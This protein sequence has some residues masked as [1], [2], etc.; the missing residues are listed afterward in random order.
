MLKINILSLLLLSSTTSLIASAGE[1][2]RK[3]LPIH[4]PK[5]PTYT[6]L[7]VRNAKAPA[8]FEIK[9]P[10][11]APNILLILI[12]DMGFGVSQTFGGPAKMPTID[13]LAKTGIR[14]NHFHT[15]SLCAP[16]RTALLS[17]RNHH[18]NN[19]G[20]ITETATAFPGNTGSTPPESAPIAKVLRYNGYS[21]AMF[22]KNH[23]TAAWEVSP[24][25]PTDRWPTR[26]GFDKFYG[27]FGGETNQWAPLIYDGMTPVEIPEDPEYN[28]MTDMTDKAIEWVS[29]QQALTPDKPFF[30][31]FAPGATHAP[32]H[33]PK[34]W[35]EKYKG[36]FDQGWDKL[37]E[38]TLARQIKQGIVP[39]GTKLAPK[40]KDIKDWDTLS[41]D[42]KRLF[43]RQMETFA[44]FA[45]YADTEIG[46]LIT[47]LEEM[48][49]LDNTLVIYIAGDNGT[50]AEGGMNGVVNEYTELN[51]VH[52]TIE[53]QLKYLDQWGN[54]KTY[55]HMAAGWAIA[56]GAPFAWAKQVAGDFGGT[57]NGMVM[58]WPKHFK[59][60]SVVRSQFAHVTDIVPTI[61]EASKI[62]AP[63]YV[64]G[65]KQL[66]IQG[67][68][69]LYTFNAPT[70]AER[71]TSQYFEMFGNRGY[72][73]DGWFAR[74]VHKKPWSGTPERSLQDD[75]WELFD[76]KV[77][78][79]LAHNLA[80][81]HPTKLRE[82]KKLFMKD[83]SL[84]HVLPIDDRSFERLNSKIAGRP[85]LM[86]GRT[87]ITLA[88]GMKDLGENVFINVK[89]TSYSIDADILFL[90]SKK[91]GVIIAQGG[92][93]GGWS[94]F[95][96]KGKASYTYNFLGQTYTTVMDKNTLPEG[97]SNVRMEFKYDGG[98]AGKGGQAT[99]FVNGKK[100][101]SKRVNRTQPALFSMDE[102]ADVGID[103]AT[104]VDESYASTKGKF[105][106][107]VLKVT[108]SI[109]PK[110]TK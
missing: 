67:K 9:T 102:T 29:F 72:Y 28:F 110:L 61:L 86:A 106:G 55:P 5:V 81:T 52:E 82:L 56:S 49:E 84:N 3:V 59:D 7:D 41:S 83:A 103:G 69:L 88:D 97:K 12:D 30:L 98:G 25:G 47:K 13:A 62:P 100:V 15:T 78:F 58:R 33:V 17:G 64:D 45:E 4:A 73:K 99:L 31:Y 87:S 23:E 46:R 76:T 16:T 20:S 2:D 68:S 22:G 37:R 104:P 26:K 39:K 85:D 50:S 92:R 70:K 74:V 109:D 65:I 44:G 89:N 10:K 71:H 60:S 53:N 96:N 40:P 66:P 24:S 77:D 32:H 27:F 80:D 18:M 75:V 34:K 8:R 107:K 14:Y 38:E 42:E 57:R 36:K 51:G 48:G 35:I 90:S 105:S 95:V 108:V 1:L 21:T 54:P 91:D 63:K 101:D 19:M 6:Q 93:F 94:L 79:S 43:A 11:D